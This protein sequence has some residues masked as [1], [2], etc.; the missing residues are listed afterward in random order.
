[1]MKLFDLV[2]YVFMLPL[3]MVIVLFKTSEGDRGVSYNADQ[4]IKDSAS[5]MENIASL[6]N[7]IDVE[8]SKIAT[9]S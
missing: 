9:Q 8:T 2:V 6:Y 5:V 1:M 7:K 4:G 3:T